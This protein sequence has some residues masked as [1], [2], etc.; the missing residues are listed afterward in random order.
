[1]KEEVSTV[2]RFF[3]EKLMTATK[4][5]VT[6]FFISLLIGTVVVLSDRT[7]AIGIILLPVWAG[8][9]LFVKWN[10]KMISERI[11]FFP[12]DLLN[13]Y[14]H[15]VFAICLTV[16]SILNSLMFIFYAAMDSIKTSNLL[17]IVASQAIAYPAVV[18]TLYYITKRLRSDWPKEGTQPNKIK[19]TEQMLREMIGR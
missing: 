9:G 7:V 11:P 18:L 4:L 6:M 15:W 17:L 5:V 2:V 1:M 13:S 19:N 16:I 10:S 3:L 14:G 8:L 12:E